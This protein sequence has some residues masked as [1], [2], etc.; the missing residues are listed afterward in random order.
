M[1]FGVVDGSD[2]CVIHNTNY[3]M[4]NQSEKIIKMRQIYEELG[5]LYAIDGQAIYDEQNKNEEVYD[6]DDE[7]VADCDRNSGYGQENTENYH[8]S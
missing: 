6:E 3:R 1:E 8:Y 4:G 7:F 2:I 5:R